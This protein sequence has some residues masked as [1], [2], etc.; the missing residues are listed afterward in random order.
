[1]LYYILLNE[2]CVP[3]LSCMVVENLLQIVVTELSPLKCDNFNEILYR[4]LVNGV[5]VFPSLN[6]PIYC[7]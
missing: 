3:E 5:P 1:M 2:I 4:D 7:Y 6:I